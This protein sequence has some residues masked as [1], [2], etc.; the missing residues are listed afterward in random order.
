[1]PR[2]LIS[3]VL[4]T[5]VAQTDGEQAVVTRGQAI[6][7]ELDSALRLVAGGHWLQGSEATQS[8]LLALLGEP[9]A[10]N[11]RPAD[12]PIG[13]MMLDTDLGFTIWWSGVAWVNAL[14]GDVAPG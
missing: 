3:P 12:P 6:D 1:M 13:Y 2:V 7:V 10:T 5:W 14:G 4:G 8:A 11:E 9:A